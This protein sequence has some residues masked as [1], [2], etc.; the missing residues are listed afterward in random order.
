MDEQLFK[1]VISSFRNIQMKR[2]QAGMS[3]SAHSTLLQ[4]VDYSKALVLPPTRRRYDGS[5]KTLHLMMESPFETSR[6]SRC[7]K[8]LEAVANLSFN[9]WNWHLLIFQLRHVEF[10][11]VQSFQRI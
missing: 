10:H 5:W 4:S 9:S 3:K 2:E 7:H 11:I 6:A 8:S 1:V